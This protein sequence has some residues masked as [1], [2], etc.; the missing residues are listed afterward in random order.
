M[1]NIIDLVPMLRDRRRRE[2][3]YERAIRQAVFRAE[4]AQL[5]LHYRDFTKRDAPALIKVQAWARR[6]QNERY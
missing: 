1:A 4:S 2:R 5:D 3:L 6:H